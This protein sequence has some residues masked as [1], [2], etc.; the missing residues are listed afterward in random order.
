M[1]DGRALPPPV[2]IFL[3]DHG[4]AHGAAQARHRRGTGPAQARQARPGTRTGTRPG[5]RPGTRLACGLHAACMRLACGLHGRCRN[6]AAPSRQRRAT[7]A[8]ARRVSG[9]HSANAGRTLK[10]L[11]KGRKD[12]KR[13]DSAQSLAVLWWLGRGGAFAAAPALRP[14]GWGALAIFGGFFGSVP[15]YSPVFQGVS[16]QTT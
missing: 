5:T 16:L 14:E 8:P 6:P 2:L 4:A 7:A 9:L 10:K 12:F 11:E 1:V 3:S 13:L 15:R